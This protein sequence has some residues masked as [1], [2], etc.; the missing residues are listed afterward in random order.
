MR[1]DPI[2]EEIH[3]VRRQLLAECGGDLDRYLDRLEE[4]QAEHP[5]RLVTT[6]E[7]PSVSPDRPGSE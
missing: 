5:E 2:V 4:L 7:R 1:N 6:V 3:A